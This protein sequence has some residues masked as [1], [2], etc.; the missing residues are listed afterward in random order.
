MISC[1]VGISSLDPSIILFSSTVLTWQRTIENEK[2]IESKLNIAL[3]YMYRPTCDFRVKDCDIALPHI[4]VFT[5]LG[6]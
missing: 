6:L 4:Y 3:I 2:K 5:Y 1:L